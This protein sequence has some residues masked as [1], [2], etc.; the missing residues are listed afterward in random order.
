[1]GNSASSERVGV[2]VGNELV[3]EPVTI[4]TDSE[5]VIGQ[6]EEMESDRVRGTESV[7]SLVS[8][9]EK[10]ESVKLSDARSVPVRD[11][12]RTSLVAVNSVSE[13]DGDKLL[14]ELRLSVKAWV[15][16]LVGGRDCDVELVQVPIVAEP[17]K[18]N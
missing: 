16:V 17:D 13:I 8:V 7:T 10:P 3:A 15:S 4:V 2:E 14:L 5:P 18:V 6:V 12:L 11:R 9:G 1:M